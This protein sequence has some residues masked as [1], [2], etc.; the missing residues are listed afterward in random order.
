MRSIKPGRGP[1]AMGAFGSIVAAVFGVIWTI[2]AASMGA[3]GIFP[4]FG[5]IF[6]ISALVG[7]V[8]NYKNAAGSNRMS[9]YDITDDNEEPDP[10]QERFHR[11]SGKAGSSVVNTINSTI[12]SAG[13]IP[14]S[15]QTDRDAVNFCPFCRCELKD[16]FKFCP[17]C[18]SDISNI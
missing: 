9:V 12:N 8:Y 5:V 3:P 4:L 17:K 2:F 15:S 11:K 16:N 10:L 6:I 1:S 13:G 7:A 18:G 14:E